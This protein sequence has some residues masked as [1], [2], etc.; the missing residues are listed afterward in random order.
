MSDLAATLGVQPPTVTKMISRLAAQD[1]VER[2]ASTGDGRQAL[3]FLT[4]RGRKAIG[5]DR[6]GVEADREG[7]AL[8]H[9][10]QGPQAPAQAPSPGRAQPRRAANG[11]DRR[12]RRGRRRR[13]RP[14]RPSADARAGEVAPEPDAPPPSGLRIAQPSHPSRSPCAAST[15]D[16]ST[17]AAVVTGGA[18]G[19]GRAV[20]ERLLADGA[21]VAIWDRDRALAERTAKRTCRP[22]QGHRRR[23]RCRRLCRRRARPRRDP[24]RPRQDRHPRQQRR[25]RRS[26]RQDLGAHAR[27]SG[28]ACI[29]STSPA[30]STAARR[31]SPA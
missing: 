5:H 31:S 17:R 8:R 19:I 7:R 15:I 13:P 26:D 20:V 23:R 3:V 4:E 29:A 21:A 16:F 25:H 28:T 27:R 11:D 14:R 10:R 24:R 9:R 2:R 1:Y 12:T 22:R 30:R 18:Q 6:Q